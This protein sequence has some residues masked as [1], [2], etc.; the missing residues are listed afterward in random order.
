[1]RQSEGDE[2]P[3]EQHNQTGYRQDAGTGT[4]VEKN[5]YES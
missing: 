2:A 4:V 1:M 5:Q 3:G